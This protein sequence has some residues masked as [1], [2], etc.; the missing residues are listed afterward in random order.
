MIHSNHLIEEIWVKEQFIKMCMD[1]KQNNVR[2]G[3]WGRQH[4]TAITT[5]MVSTRKDEQLYSNK[6]DNLEEMDNFLETV[7]TESSRNRPT[8]QTDH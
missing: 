7:K 1:R 6:F 2:L 8:E 4:P 5:K 3:G